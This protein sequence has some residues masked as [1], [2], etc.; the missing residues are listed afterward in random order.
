M[1]SFI[2]LFISNEPLEV[3]SNSSFLHII[4]EDEKI[5]LENG[6]DSEKTKN[7]IIIQS[8]WFKCHTI[9]I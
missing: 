2:F 3:L 5:A 4:Q 1:P 9:S 8:V 7:C 6:I